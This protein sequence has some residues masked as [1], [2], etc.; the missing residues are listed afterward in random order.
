MTLND[1]ASPG[2]SGWIRSTAAGTAVRAV[3]AAAVIAMILVALLVY[4]AD[5]PG[6]LLF[7]AFIIV[8][9]QLPGQLLLR[10]AGFRPEHFS[11]LLSVGFFTGWAFITLQYFLTELIPTDLLLYAA[12]PVCTC[13]Y[14]ILL[15]KGRTDALKASSHARPKL[16]EISPA[17]CIFITLG[18]LYSMLLTQY[19]YLSPAYDQTITMNPDKGF[20]LGLINSLSH[21]YPLECPWFAGLYYNYHIFTELLYSVPVRLFGMTADVILFECGPFL[22]VYAFTVSLYSLFQEMCRKSS[23]AGLYCLALMLSNI[24]IARGIDR[25]IAFLFIFRN[26]NVAAYGVSCAMVLV[27]MIRYW[28]REHAEGGFAWRKLILLIGVLM[29]VTGIKGPFA[30]VTV[31]ALWGT[32][33]LGLILRKVKFKTIL[34]LVLLTVG[35][36][37]VYSTVLGSKGQHASAGES[38]IALANILN[39]T[40]FKSPLVALMK[41]LGVPMI[42]RYLVLLAVFT[43][44]LLT[45][46][47]L[48]FVIGYIRE[49][50]LV[51][52]GRKEFDFSRVFVYAAVL[53]GYIAMLLLNYHGHSQ[54]Y[55]GFVTVFFAPLIAFW[56]FEDMEEKRGALMK[57]IRGIFI[58]C[59][60]LS[61]VGLGSFM[62]TQ[63]HDAAE[64][65]DPQAH[66]SKY[67]SMSQK[68]YDAMRWIDQNTPKD[69]LLATDRYYS[70]SPKKFDVK[71]RWD[72]RFFLYADYSN[73]I[74][75][76]AGAGY[77]LPAREWQKRQER[78]ETNDRFFDRKDSGR[79]DLARELGI[80]YVVVSKRFTHSGDLSN[81]DYHL[82]YSN[83]DVDV[84][85]ITQ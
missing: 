72:N 61:A 52:I 43:V 36:Y 45:A 81:R 40:F 84:Y 37:I 11:T 58:G 79:G 64:S 28:Y 9:V 75:Y 16:R 76:L 62:L 46:F 10:A 63:S 21:G 38:I 5:L 27:I 67:T 7:F 23:R 30:L 32:F 47:F 24:F 54:I 60:V 15:C 22:T 3:C 42:L 6:I 85:E 33:A 68:E 55:F 66:G 78:I 44:C 69:S 8:Y 31:A 71:D 13:L 53:V 4:H 50:I 70:V 39:I 35:F 65:A 25:S 74:C 80:D 2:F 20:H 14:L 34:P 48:P 77:N 51:L 1:T 73:R 29:L 57:L 18:L 19:L 59:L 82:Y 56:F 41:S 12:G 83:E 49:L 17:L 26:E